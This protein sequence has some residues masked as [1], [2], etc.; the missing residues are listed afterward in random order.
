MRNA[1]HDSTKLVSHILILLCANG[2]RAE[3]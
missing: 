1:K 3:L 2:S